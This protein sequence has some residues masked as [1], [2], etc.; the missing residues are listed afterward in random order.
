MP[1]RVLSPHRLGSQNWGDGQTELRNDGVLRSSD[2]GSC[3][4]LTIE[5]APPSRPR[6]RSC[7][8]RKATGPACDLAP[9]YDYPPCQRYTER[10][11][12]GSSF[13]ATRTTNRR[14]STSSTASS[15]PS[16][17]WKTQGWQRTTGLRANA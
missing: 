1:A 8:W 14:T 11:D 13:S 4:F 12:I 5:D 2:A 16:S 6:A 7:R 15:R 3:C 17:G 10:E 9:L